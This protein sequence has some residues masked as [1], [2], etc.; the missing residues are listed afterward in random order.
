[1][2]NLKELGYPNIEQLYLFDFVPGAGGDFFITLASKCS[3]DFV[4]CW[5]DD[6]DMLGR[7]LEFEETSKMPGNNIGGK[8][9]D[10]DT[11][12][13]YKQQILADLYSVGGSEATKMSF[14]THPT[15]NNVNTRITDVLKHCFPDIPITRVCLFT[16]SLLSKQFTLYSYY[17]L[18]DFDGHYLD[19]LQDETSRFIFWEDPEN[20]FLI[21]HINLF[22][23][24]PVKFK[25][26]V[27]EIAG[28]VNWTWYTK[29]TEL[30]WQQKIEPFYSQF[31]EVYG[32]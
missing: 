5:Q 31:K 10:F 4:N 1:M 25:Q 3:S 20:S 30:Y 28:T 9:I 15:G 17:D 12:G 2:I 27:L 14:C 16:N 13:E 8:L 32:A 29:I 11:I 7:M 26:A 24:D 22:I 19:T 18:L 21:D 6:V 23:N